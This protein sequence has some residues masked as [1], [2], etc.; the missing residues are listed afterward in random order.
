M[1]LFRLARLTLPGLAVGFIAGVLA[2]GLAAFV[3]Q[4]AGWALVSA[5][6]LGVP[7]GLLG[8]GYTMLLINGKIRLGGFA[9]AA[10]YWLIGFPLARML[11]EVLTRLVLTGQP[12]L[13]PD[14]LGFLA[15]QGIVSAGFAIGF[16]W[17][18]ERVAPRY[19]QRLAAHDPD[20][21]D[22]YLRYAEHAR[23][24]FEAAERRKAARGRKPSARTSVR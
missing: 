19:W 9:P 10:A 6:T 21:R 22:V 23:A 11:H 17:L 12:G 3:G 13:P 24:M 14:P 15:Y 2:G 20:A 1:H 16:L 7:L 18:H 5:L 8:A 4:P